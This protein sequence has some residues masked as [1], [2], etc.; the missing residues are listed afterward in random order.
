[1]RCWRVAAAGRCRWATQ[2]ELGSRVH[3]LSRERACWR[4]LLVGRAER[5]GAGP[6]GWMWAAGKRDG[7]RVGLWFWVLGW[8]FLFYFCF[9]SLFLF[10]IQTQLKLYLFEFKLK[11]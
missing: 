3:S 9:L 2:Q 10:P 11:I 4:A 6:A 7:L 8:V 5:R 1:M